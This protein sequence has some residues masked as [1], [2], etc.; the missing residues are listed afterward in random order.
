MEE[1]LHKDKLEEFFKN[2]FDDN[3]IEPSE[4]Q[5]DVPSDAVWTGINESIN[6]AGPSAASASVLNLKW[7][8]AVAASVLIIGLLYYNY[9]LQRQVTQLKEL[10]EYQENTIN[11]LLE[12]VS[13][14]DE[15]KRALEKTESGLMKG[16]K[17]GRKEE[18]RNGGK[19]ENLVIGKTEDNG[20]KMEKVEGKKGGKKEGRNGGNWSA[21][22][23][24]ENAVENNENL[25]F[26]SDFKVSKPGNSQ[27]DP[28]AFTNNES[29]PKQNTNLN[30]HDSEVGEFDSNNM[31]TRKI[32]DVANSNPVAEK[33]PVVVGQG[34]NVFDEPFASEQHP[35]AVDPQNT[36]IKASTIALLDPVSTK[37]IFAEAKTAVEDDTL[38]LL[39]L[40]DGAFPPK[41]ALS[42]RIGFY[43][44]AHIAP[45]Y[46][47]RN[48]RS[49]NGPVLRRL[50]NEQEQAIY[51]VALGMKA[52][53][54]FNKN[55]SVETG[56]NYFENNVRSMHRAQVRYESQIERLNTDGNY[57]SN[58]QLKLSTSYGEIETDVALTRSSDTEIDQNDYINLVLKTQ[59]KLKYL[60]VPVAV[61]YRTSGNKFHFSAKA[62]IAANF[63]IQK[64]VRIKAAAVNRNGVHHRRTLVD[65]KFS[66]LKN[67]TVDFLF[68]IGIDYDI[69]NYL[70]IYFEPTVTH[71]ISPVYQLNGKIKTYP[72]I[73]SL[74]IGLAYRF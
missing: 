10:V 54:Q 62:G 70:S 47:Y 48:I 67:T 65:R 29:L 20:T 63:I 37:T 42:T 14:E 57:D 59:Q 33:E 22:R 74:N 28:D 31:D 71:S 9:T 19:E 15:E 49:V 16:G 52:G 51:S 8:L 66:G 34:D 21:A 1:N 32:Q 26:E 23:D 45:T 46:G 60:G 35:G 43:V 58:Y 27:K 25:G 2:S 4:D 5:W 30:I 41:S 61:R 11:S 39:P 55:W 12:Q 3:N 50:L 53:Y 64:D 18:G 68:G 7:L 13:K 44:G 72:I 17:N 69:S 56:L 73:A 36:L 40:A 38:E 24:D 6:P